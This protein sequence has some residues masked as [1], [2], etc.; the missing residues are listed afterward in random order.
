[1]TLENYRVFG[2]VANICTK[3]VH[4]VANLNMVAGGPNFASPLHGVRR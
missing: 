3:C 1:M 4:S 2:L